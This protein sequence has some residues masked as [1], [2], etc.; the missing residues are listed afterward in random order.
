MLT[1]FKST[2]TQF[3]YPVTQ[4]KDTVTNVYKS[5]YFNN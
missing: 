1:Q 5:L 3:K 4:W 2:V